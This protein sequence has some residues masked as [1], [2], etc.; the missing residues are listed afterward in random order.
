MEPYLVIPKTPP[1]RVE[2]EYIYD[3]VVATGGLRN[4]FAHPPLTVWVLREGALDLSFSHGFDPIHARKGDTVFLP[5]VAR[6]HSMTKGTRLLS[7]RFWMTS[8]FGELRWKQAVP[9]CLRDSTSLLNQLGD[10]LTSLTAQCYGTEPSHHRHPCNVHP[11]AEPELYLEWTSVFAQWIHEFLRLTRQTGWEV[12]TTTSLMPC[13]DQSLSI[14]D[15]GGWSSGVQGEDL[16]AHHGISLSQFKR[17][18]RQ[19]TGIGFK[20]WLEKERFRRITSAF[21]N[22]ELQ[23]KEIAYLFGFSSPSHFSAWFKR[24]T[25]Q[26]PRV[27]RKTVTRMGV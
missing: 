6:T 10:Q 20:A 22:Q 9:F 8:P 4:T 5:S 7:C 21:E 24:Q 14:M 27:Y 15:S 12:Q 13:A 18:I 26:P 19:E 25:G 3:D 17:R 2:L 11:S 1:L 16:A 23:L